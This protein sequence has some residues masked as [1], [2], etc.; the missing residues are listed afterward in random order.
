[1]PK[2]KR[3]LTDTDLSG[4]VFQEPTTH[5]TPG[6]NIAAVN[7]WRE[8][9]AGWSFGQRYEELE[10]RAKAMRKGRK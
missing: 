9:C 4:A 3:T 7:A 1:M 5:G 6:S 10:R 8:E 2:R